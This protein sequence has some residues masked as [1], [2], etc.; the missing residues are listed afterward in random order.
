[1]PPFCTKAEHGLYI[2]G[3]RPSRVL[4]ANNGWVQG[5]LYVYNWNGAFQFQV[6]HREDGNWIVRYG[7]GIGLAGDRGMRIAVDISLSNTIGEA[8]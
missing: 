2:G 5:F 1:M 4:T 7:S 3:G 6:V 8:D